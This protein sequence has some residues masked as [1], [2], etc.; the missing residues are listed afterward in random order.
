[1]LTKI[2]FKEASELYEQML[3]AGNEVAFSSEA[4]D[5]LEKLRE[6]LK[7]PFNEM[8]VKCFDFS[9]G[10]G[11]WPAIQQALVKLQ[12]LQTRHPNLSISVRQIKE[13]FGDL[14][15]YND[16]G[17]A[18]ASSC[19]IAD[20]AEIE[21][22]WQ[23]VNAIVQELYA[24]CSGHCEVCG[25]PGKKVGLSWVRTLCEKHHTKEV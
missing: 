13:K 2:Q 23:D 10:P 25:E 5:S 20:G 6:E 21:N 12:A 3:A 16:V 9:A 18:E 17:I 1:M 8:F 11:W 15:F 14:R 24:A 22:V 4:L 19:T 7:A